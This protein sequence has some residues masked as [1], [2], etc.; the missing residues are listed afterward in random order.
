MLLFICIWETT[1]VNAGS[2]MDILKNE[3]QKWK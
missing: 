3:M 1:L 2:E